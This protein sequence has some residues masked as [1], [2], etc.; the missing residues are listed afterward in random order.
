ML[1]NIQLFHAG[2]EKWHQICEAAQKEAPVSCNGYVNLRRLCGFVSAHSGLKDLASALSK[3]LVPLSG[4]QEAIPKAKP[5]A[6]PTAAPAASNKRSAKDMKFE[7]GGKFDDLP[8]AKMGE[9]VVRFPPEASG[10][11]HIGHAKAAL[12]NFHYKA[13]QNVLLV[14]T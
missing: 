13:C 11:M 7:E 2:T 1:S 10:F 8:G 4:A 6:A 5:S 14:Q 3:K 12:L 9:V